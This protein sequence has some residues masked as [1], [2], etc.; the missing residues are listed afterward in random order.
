LPRTP[1]AKAR[2]T[3]ADIRNPARHRGRNDPSVAPLGDPS[4]FLADDQR[5]VWRQFQAEIPWL[6]ESDRSLV[7]LATILRTRMIAGGEV[8]VNQLQVLSAVLS[9]L[10]ATPVDRSRINAPADDEEPDEFFGNA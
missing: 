2:I 3:G 1:V 7:E 6:V 10:G 4:T 8:G 9:K 5:E